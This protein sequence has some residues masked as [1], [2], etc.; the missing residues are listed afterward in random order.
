VIAVRTQELCPAV[1][2]PGGEGCSPKQEKPMR[3]LLT[4]AVLTFVA[5]LGSAEA[6]GTKGEPGTPT[7]KL[8]GHVLAPPG[9]LS[10]FADFKNKGDLGVPLYLV[11]RTGKPVELFT[12]NG[13]P[14][15]AVEYEAE[16]GKWKPARVVDSALCGNSLSPLKLPDETFLKVPGY[17]AA[18]GFKAKV[19]Y[20]LDAAGKPLSNAGEGMVSHDDLSYLL[21]AKTSNLDLLSKVATGEF[22]P[23]TESANV[24]PLAIRRLAE[25]SFARDKAEAVLKCIADGTDKEYARIANETLEF[26]RK[27]QNQ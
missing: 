2:S 21:V 5:N 23:P 10:L 3:S 25:G 12:F 9:K 11:N 8:P 6:P 26:I 1:A 20:R 13:Q 16:P 7:A 18:V 17:V 15:L 22:I 19:R 27:F 4:L 14:F 24:R